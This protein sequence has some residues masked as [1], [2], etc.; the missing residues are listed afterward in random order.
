MSVPG[1]ETLSTV[2]D[3]KITVSDETL[4]TVEDAKTT[5]SDETLS[6]VEDPKTTAFDS[7]TVRTME[8]SHT[9]HGRTT[10]TTD[11]VSTHKVS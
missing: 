11:S 1:S 4:S 10:E 5:V 3:A 6:T 9:T 8:G 2:G 7:H